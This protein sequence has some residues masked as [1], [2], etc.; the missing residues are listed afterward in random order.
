MAGFFINEEHHKSS[1]VIPQ[2]TL[3]YFLY[4]ILRK[5]NLLMGINTVYKS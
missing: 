4:N 3:K 1:T 5:S 2:P